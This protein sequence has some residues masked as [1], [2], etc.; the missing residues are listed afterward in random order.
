MSIL[1]GESDC[2]KI[3]S[4]VVQL[5]ERKTVNLV[6]GGSKPSSGAKNKKEK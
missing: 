6:V 3:C 4:G 2:S 5:V 1:S